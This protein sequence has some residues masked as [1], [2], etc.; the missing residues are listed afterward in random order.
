MRSR[1][2][3]DLQCQPVAGSSRRRPQ[4]RR[5]IPVVQ[6]LAEATTGRAGRPTGSGRIKVA[7][8]AC[9]LE[10]KPARGR[11]EHQAAMGK[12]DRQVRIETTRP[13][14]AAS[15]HRSFKV[16]YPA[17]N[18]V[19]SPCQADPSEGSAAVNSSPRSGRLHLHRAPIEAM[20]L[21]PVV[22]FFGLETF[23]PMVV[24]GLEMPARTL[25]VRARPAAQA[26]ACSATVASASGQCVSGCG[27]GAPVSI[28]RRNTAA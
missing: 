23:Q 13:R 20:R 2:A 8:N 9:I 1:K 18:P 4:T 5:R 12:P 15:R 3:V 22:A 6:L 10:A 25:P 28:R 26:A 27:T 21:K 24:A 19:G 7:T 14:T 17:M 11:S 16:G